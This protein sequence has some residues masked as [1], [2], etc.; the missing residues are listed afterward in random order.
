MPDVDRIRETARDWYLRLS[1]GYVSRQERR[2]FEA[3]QRADPAHAAAYAEIEA[4]LGELSA[5]FK[6]KPRRW[7][8]VALVA[9]AGAGFVLI[10]DLFVQLRADHVT[11]VGAQQRIVLPDGGIAHLNTDTALAI[12]YG[13]DQRVVALLRGEAV[14]DVTVDPGRP[15]TV[16]VAGGRATATGTIYG[17]HFG[18]D[19]TVSVLEGTVTVASDGEERALGEGDASVFA[20]GLPPAPARATEPASL[21]WRDGFIIIDNT[22]LADAVEE[23]DRYLPGVSI[24][25]GQA[26]AADVAGQIAIDAAGEGLMAIAATVGAEVTWITPYLRIIR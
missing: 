6:P 2:A 26:S 18:E 17:V 22:P 16:S 25:V 9:A 5:S 12:H 7:P 19:V 1:D 21:A 10:P 3:W 20:E 11:G 8:A 13:P 14:F 4:A 15:F 24:V 23:I